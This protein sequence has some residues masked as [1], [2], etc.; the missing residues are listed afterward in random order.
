MKSAYEL[1]MERFGD[2][3][4]VQQLSDEQKKA[5]GELDRICKARIAEAEIMSRERMKKTH[6][7][8]AQL[9]QIRTD[10]VVE[11]ASIREKSE[12]K[13]ERIRNGEE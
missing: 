11:I 2:K 13:K 4:P 5:I 10:L 3:N 1:A 12:R 9:E 8:A 6:G 7:D